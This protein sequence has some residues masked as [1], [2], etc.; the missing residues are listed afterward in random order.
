MRF[1][2]PALLAALLVAPAAANDVYRTV[3][4]RGV[5]VYSDRPLSERSEAVRIEGRSASREPSGPQAAQPAAAPPAA[6]AGE[7]SSRRQREADQAMLAAARAEQGEIRAAACREARNA[8]EVYETSPRL[9]ETL[10]DGSRRFLSDEEMVQA[11]VKARQAV[12]NFC[13]D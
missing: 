10:P 11:R 6:P 12:A 8:L 1:L 13:D 2:V 5:V 4:E 9:F 7:Q 3:D